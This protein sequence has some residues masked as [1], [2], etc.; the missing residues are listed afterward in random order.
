MD[1][2]TMIDPNQG[3][4]ICGQWIPRARLGLHL[5]LGGLA[6]HIEAALTAKDSATTAALMLSY[7]HLAGLNTGDM[8]DKEKLVAYLRLTEL[9]QLKFMLPFQKWATNSNVT[10]PPYDYSGRTWAWWIHKLASRYG[11]TGEYILNLWPEEAAAYLQEIMIAEFDE[12]DEARALSNLAYHYDKQTQKSTF[13][14][15]PR[16]AWM[17]EDIGKKKKIY[18][19]R[20]EMLPMGH[21]INLTNK[22]EIIH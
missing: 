5:R 18:H 15:L 3:A 9:N 22:T 16:P 20:R 10:K 13:R 14:P 6:A 12:S 21:I 17:K 4:D 2:L 11:W 1:F 7:F 19:V 8:S